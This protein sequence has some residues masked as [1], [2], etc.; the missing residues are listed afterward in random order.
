MFCKNIASIDAEFGIYQTKYTKG[1][2]NITIP[3]ITQ[4][5]DEVKLTLGDINIDLNL[6]VITATFFEIKNN[7]HNV[8][9]DK[10]SD[11]AII[12][13]PGVLTVEHL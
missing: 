8:Q 6:S 10:F 5:L 12:L 7:Y 1:G 4:Y 3:N 2:V 11:D 13:L 9:C